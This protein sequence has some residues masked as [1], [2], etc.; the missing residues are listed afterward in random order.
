MET[1][2]ERLYRLLLTYPQASWT[3]KELAA[4]AGCSRGYVSR[5]AGALVAEGVLG[6]PYKNRVVLA[7]PTKLLLRWGSR[8]TLPPPTYV[9]ASGDP[10]TVEG[11][12]R[13]HPRVALTLFRAAWHR[14]Q[15][16]RTD[17]LEAYVPRDRVQAVARALGT[18]AEEP[19]SLVLYPAEGPEFEGME[20]VQGLPLVSVPQNV[21][22]L[23]AVGGQG[24]RVALHLARARGLLGD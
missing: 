8:R 17:S 13:E 14:T 1:A 4:R 21:V 9:A 6:R 19:T 2:T 23:L 5:V 10:E 16:L 24:P 12:L 18:P 15:F 11:R 22:D 7:A 3:Q 20:R